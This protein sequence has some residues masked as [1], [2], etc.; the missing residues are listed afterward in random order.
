MSIETYNEKK[1]KINNY[2]FPLHIEW[3]EEIKIPGFS[4]HTSRN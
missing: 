3:R 4:D 1:S 2:L